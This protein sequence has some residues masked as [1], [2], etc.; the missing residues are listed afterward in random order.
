MCSSDLLQKLG[1]SN[2]QGLLLH[3]PLRYID[4]TRI[5]AIRDLR[6]GDDAQCEGE[7]IHAEVNVAASLEGWKCQAFAG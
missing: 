5:T 6:Q 1:I 3:L 4:E 2:T 7:V